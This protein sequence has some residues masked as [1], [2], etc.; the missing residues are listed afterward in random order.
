MRMT[1]LR[2]CPEWLGSLLLKWKW[3]RRL[4]GMEEAAERPPILWVDDS[5]GGWRQPPDWQE[6]H[7]EDIGQH[8]TWKRE[9]R[10][11]LWR[12][13]GGGSPLPGVVNLR[14]VG[15]SDTS[16]PQAVPRLWPV[17]VQLAEASRRLGF[18]RLAQAAMPEADAEWLRCVWLEHARKVEEEAESRRST[19]EEINRRG[20]VPSRTTPDEAAREA[21]IDLDI[22]PLDLPD[23]EP[24]APLRSL[25][26]AQPAR[27]EHHAR[28]TKTR[29]A[30]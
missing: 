17:G 1:L 4:L 15:L 28:Y 9:M 7:Y 24:R 19:I 22:G 5:G 14:D 23:D 6:P 8:D 30:K 2:W 13:R 20:P 10:I 25:D 12:V 26:V 3:G 18:L 16:R 27:P 29:S 21:R 11:F